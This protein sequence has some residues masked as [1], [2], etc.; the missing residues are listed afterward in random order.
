MKKVVLLFNGFPTSRESKTISS[1]Q[2]DKCPRISDLPEDKLDTT[3]ILG[4]KMLLA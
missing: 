3:L 2:S 1:V 4:L